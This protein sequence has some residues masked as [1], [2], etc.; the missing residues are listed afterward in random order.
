MF[1]SWFQQKRLAGKHE[2][3]YRKALLKWVIH[4]KKWKT[5]KVTFTQSVPGD[6][7]ASGTYH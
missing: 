7:F 2:Q 3:K 1:S 4:Y 5:V 6:S